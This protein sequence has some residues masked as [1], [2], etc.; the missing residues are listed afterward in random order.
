MVSGNLQS[1]EAGLL[2]QNWFSD[3][4]PQLAWTRTNAASYGLLISISLGVP[5][6]DHLESDSNLLQ[7]TAGLLDPILKLLNIPYSFIAPF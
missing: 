4:I 7:S 1:G 6:N 2:L 5:E 3:Q